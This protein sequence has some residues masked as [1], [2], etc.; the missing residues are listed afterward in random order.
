VNT[1]SHH[2]QAVELSRNLRTKPVRVYF[3]GQPI[4]LFRTAKGVEALIDRCPHRLV[5][6]SKG[7]IVG[8]DIECPYHG[9]RF[10]GKG[11]CTA[12]PCSIGA[13]PNYRIKS[14]ATRERGSVIFV[15]NSMLTTEP[16]LHCMEEQDVI[17]RQVKSNTTSTV[18]DAAENILDATHTHF[19][20]K[21]LL[22]GLSNKRYVVNVEVT[23]GAGWVEA[24]YT[25]E[26][27]QQGMS[28]EL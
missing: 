10:S 4:V 18:I 13:L 28:V 5:E 19:T 26:E 12:I 20:H 2:W 24:D 8:D 9:W 14:F 15:A 1:S 3:D 7:R 22:R 16:Y 21:G 23:G 17:V 6:L 11:L 27:K 25:G